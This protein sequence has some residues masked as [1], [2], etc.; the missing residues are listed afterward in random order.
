MT[1]TGDD[2]SLRLQH[3]PS[4]PLDSRPT[5]GEIVRQVCPYLV[6]DEGDWRSAL[7]TKD[8]RC[9]A[10]LPAA[11]PALVKQRDLCLRTGHTG[12]A[13]YGAARDLEAAA[14]TVQADAEDGLWPATRA[15][16]LAL[17]APRSR[18]G[19][20]PGTSGRAGGQAM[21]IGLMVLAFLVV[22]IART[23]P[24]SGTGSS[25]PGSVAPGLAG[26]SPSPVAASSSSSRSERPSPTPSP[27][28]PAP[29]G[30]PSASPDGT[31]PPS[32]SPRARPTSTPVSDRRYV[33]E[34]GD[35]LSSIA[36]AL[37]TTVRKLKKANG[38]TSNVIRPGQELVV[39]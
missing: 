26:G 20:L 10:T 28:P 34:S 27:S 7:P 30:S 32:A 17:E 6:A 25:P 9:S 4:T 31:P 13:T 29:S 39:P 23:A 19:L 35:T 22:V 16:V 36:A 12:C 33:V 38:L 8:H 14:S 24:P 18:V 21:L 3:E 37:G 1:V 11:A 5:P 2:P 15:T